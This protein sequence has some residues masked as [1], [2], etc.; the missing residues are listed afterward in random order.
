MAF[1]AFLKI[2]G[3]E[4]DSTASKHKGEIEVLSFSWNIRQPTSTGG[5]G[6]G[7]SAGKAVPSDFSIV[8]HVDKAS[9]VLMVAVCS[10]QHFQDALFTVEARGGKGGEAFLKIKL[11]DVLISSYQTGG[12]GNDVPTDQVSLNFAKVEIAVRDDRGAWAEAESCDFQKG[13]SS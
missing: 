13:T 8:K 10:G 3:I 7:G 11:S 9:P 2:D 1:D 12:G 4:G 6:G 5:T